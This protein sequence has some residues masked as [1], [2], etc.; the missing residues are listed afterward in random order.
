MTIQYYANWMG[1][2][3]MDWYR[4]R[5]LTRNVAGIEEIITHCSG[6]RIDIHGTGDDYPDEIALPIMLDECYRDFR[7]WLST[8]ETDDVWTLEQLVEF[9]ERDNPKIVWAESQFPEIVD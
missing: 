5:G 9:Y 3:S 2:V 4:K 1:V 7:D 8:F 6:G